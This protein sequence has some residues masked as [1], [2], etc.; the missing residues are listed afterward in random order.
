V[1][2]GRPTNEAVIRQIQQAWAEAQAQ[3]AILREQ[4]EHAA[5]LAQTKVRSNV[6]ERDLDKAYR[7]LGEAVWAE[8]SKGKLQLPGQL[9]PVKKALE[10]VTVKI[11]AQNASINDLL[12]EG[13]DIARRLQEKMARASKAVANAPKKR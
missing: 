7:D 6:L 12:S 2:E 9:A 11:Q 1:T 4:V 13:A 3:L 8:V 10:A 5:A